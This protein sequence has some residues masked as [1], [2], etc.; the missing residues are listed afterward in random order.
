MKLE[1]LSFQEILKRTPDVFEAVV[2]ASHRARQINARRAAERIDFSEEYPEDE[3]AVPEPVDEEGF[4]EEE[5]SSVL[6]MEDFLDGHLNWRYVD[7]DNEVEA[8]ES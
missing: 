2:V 5:K 3:Y 1:T 6:A 7:R 8:E 4:V